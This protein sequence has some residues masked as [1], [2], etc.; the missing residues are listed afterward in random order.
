MTTTFTPS[1]ELGN[2][3]AVSQHTEVGSD[4][5]SQQMVKDRE[6]GESFSLR[7]SQPV[8]GIQPPSGPFELRS[9]LCPARLTRAGRLEEDID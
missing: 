8:G 7:V 6:P 1:E 2:L 3:C 4:E 9:K 5:P